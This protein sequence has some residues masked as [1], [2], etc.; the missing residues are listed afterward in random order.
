[1]DVILL[2]SKIHQACVTDVNISYEG[3]IVID[4][5]LMDETGLA[6]YEKV[7]VA[8]IANGNRFETYV[9]EGEAGSRKIALNGAAARLGEIGDRLIIMAFARVHAAEA[10]TFSP[11]IVQLDENNKIIGRS[12]IK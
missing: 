6:A 10:G 4:R 11:K 5:D 1:M 12:D 9:I 2:K 8:N 3:S 7:L